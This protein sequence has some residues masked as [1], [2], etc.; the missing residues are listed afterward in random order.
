MEA[1]VAHLRQGTGEARITDIRLLDLQGRDVERSRIGE[2][3]VLRISF[4]CAGPLPQPIALGA[5]ICDRHGIMAVQFMSDDHGMTIEETQSGRHVVDFEFENCLTDGEYSVNA[6]LSVQGE[7]PGYVNHR[8]AMH[9]I[10]AV[11]GGLLFVALPDE[12]RPVW[13]KVRIPVK[14]SQ[15][16]A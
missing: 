16:P 15:H 7:R 2:T 11:F 3:L 8:I 1:R 14:I 5:G 12:N 9:A 10:D 13:G 4:E 6:G